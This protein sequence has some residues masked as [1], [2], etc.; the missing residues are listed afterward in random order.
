[1]LSNLTSKLGRVFEDALLF[2]TTCMP[3]D[4]LSQIGF[5]HLPKTVA[6]RA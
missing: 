3:D 5:S 4:G 2:A 1:M 6:T